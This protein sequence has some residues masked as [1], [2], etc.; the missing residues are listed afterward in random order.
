MQTTS[1]KKAKPVFSGSVFQMKFNPMFMR[2]KKAHTNAPARAPVKTTAAKNSARF[3][4]LCESRHPLRE[5]PQ[6]GKSVRR[7]GLRNCPVYRLL[8][9]LGSHDCHKIG[10]R[11]GLA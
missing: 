2:K 4:I 8:H 9:G 3:L 6:R 1:G 7:F 5:I 10:V 11:F